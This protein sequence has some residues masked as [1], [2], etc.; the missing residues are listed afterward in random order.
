M[1]SKS[2]LRAG[3]WADTVADMWLVLGTVAIVAVILWAWWGIVD[4]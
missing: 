4:G 1:M 2:R 3:Q